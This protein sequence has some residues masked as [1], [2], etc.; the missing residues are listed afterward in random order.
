MFL[1]LAQRA[2]SRYRLLVWG[3]IVPMLI[4][5]AARDARADD[6]LQYNRDI[7]PILMENC[8]ACHGPDSAARKAKLRLDDRDVALKAGVIVPGKPAESE[9]VRRINAENAKE[10]MPPVSSHKS[11]NATQKEMLKQWIAEGAAYQPHWSFLAPTR[12]ELPKVKNAAWV[13]N[14]IDNF[15]LAKLEKV[16][17]Q[18]AAEADRRTLARRLSLD[19]T[20]LPPSPADVEAFVNDKAPNAYEKYVDKLLASPHWGEHR[21]RYWLDAAR[22]ADTHGLHFDN[23]RE[24]WAYRDWVIDAFN[25]NLSFDKFTIEQLAGD[26][27]PSPTLEQLIASGFNRCNVSTNE[28]GTIQEENLVL[29]TRDRTETV[30]QIWLGL[31]ANCAVCHD[32][33]YDKF[34]TKDFYSLAAFFN[35]SAVGALDGNIPN[36][37]PIVFVPRREDRPRWD[38]LAKDLAALRAKVEARKQN[39]KADFNKWLAAIKPGDLGET[40]PTKDLRFYMPLDEGAGKRL[41][42]TIDGKPRSA[43]LDTGFDWAAGN[44]TPK[45]FAMKAGKSLELADIGD[46]EKD[47]PFSAG[48]WVKLP[49][50]GIMGALA[51]RMDNDNIYRGWDLWMEGDRP[52]M[53]IINRWQDNAIKVLA[54]TPLQPNQWYHVLVTYDGS[55]KAAGLAVY[56][57]GVAQDFEVFADSLTETIRTPT[58]FKVGQRK[59]VNRLPNDV[60]MQDLRLYS[61][62]LPTT[63]VEQLVYG[64]K[65]KA[66]LAKPAAKRNAKETNDVFEWWLAV[67]DQTYRELK[68]SLAAYQREE[69]MVRSRGAITHVMQ[70]KKT[71]AEAYILYRG[72]YDKRRDKVSAATPTALLPMPAD[73]PKNRLGFAKWLLLPEHPL[74]ARVTVNRFWQEIFGTGLVRT[75]GDFGIT[76]E[77]PSHPELLDWLAVEFRESGWDVK[78]FVKLLVTSAA[79]RQAAVT[80]KEKLEKDPQNLLLSRGPRFRMDAE[81]IRDYALASS[82]LLVT[83]LGGP[84]VKP[85]QPL[86]VWEVVGMPESNT[87]IYKPDSGEKLYRRSIYTFWKRGAPP[88]T[89]EILNAPSRE[90]CTVQ[91]ERTNTPQQAL[92]TLNDP[93]FV[94]AARHLAQIALKEGGETLEG[95]LDVMAKRLLSR[96]MRDPEVKVVKA[97]VKDLL[98]HYKALPEEAKKLINVGESRPD[99]TLDVPTLAAWTMVANQLMNLDEVLTK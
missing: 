83:K 30:S 36:T 93:Q 20:G 38:E 11:L 95:R 62:A 82:G 43:D 70:E 61:R 23:Y 79:Y 75:A 39:A 6:K 12:P 9:V 40:V 7:R 5:L 97:M 53:H 65:T 47:Q 16:G 8:F 24:M 73:L 57:N 90:F 49:K 13:R 33:K 27:L 94:E 32:H 98:E 2:L 91:R 86:G 1:D 28:G 4:A 64:A 72:E 15:V 48:V 50:R 31:T 58:P 88:P 52:G 3:L 78:K 18:P 84:S 66:I 19:L 89:L 10:R 96:P 85:Y 25:R 63:E 87:R 68:A 14:P 42:Y 37:P 69:G 45:A 77:M 92:V 54:K 56:V 41:H 46:F 99:A 71:A 59:S 60:V 21:A 44:L 34:P 55:S 80:T 17:L 35:N 22:Y 29:Y 67:Q 51:A 74:T 26:L 76:G 81:M